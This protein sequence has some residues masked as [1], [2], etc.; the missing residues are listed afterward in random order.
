MKTFHFFRIE[1]HA[2]P[3]R[4]NTFTVTFDESGGGAIYTPDQTPQGIFIL[5]QGGRIL[6]R[7]GETETSVPVILTLRDE[8]L[9]TFNQ[10]ET[11]CIASPNSYIIETAVFFFRQGLMTG[12]SG[13]EKMIEEIRS[14]NQPPIP[15]QSKE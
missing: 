10:A 5:E 13:L 9:M 3:P 6:E 2:S 8:L 14:S 15:T 12:L 1:R 4:I 11:N 7:S